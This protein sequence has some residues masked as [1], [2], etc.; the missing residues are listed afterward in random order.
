MSHACHYRDASL[1]EHAVNQDRL[2][3]IDD[4]SGFRNYARRVGEASGFETFITDSASEFKEKVRAWRPTVIMLDL[5]MPGADGIE[6]LRDLAETKSAARILIA[7]GVDAKVLDAAQ[8]IASERGLAMAGTLAKPVRLSTLRQT[9]EA[10]REFETPLLAGAL[11]YA[12]A[13]DELLLE[14]Q[15]K[16]NCRMGEIYGV[17]A[18]I[19]WQHPTRGLVAPDNFIPLAEQSGLI[20][21]M[22]QWVVARATQQAASWRREG[23]PLDMAIN[24]SAR[25]LE[26]M[27]LPDLL[28]ASCSEAG[29][30]TDSVT[31]EITESAAM[32]DPT[33]TMDVLTRLRLKGFNL[34]IDDFGTGYS[35]LVQLR[36]L[37]L[38]EIK[39]D[40]SFVMQMQRSLDSR[41]IV[42][43]VIGLGQKL[44]HNVVAEGVETLEIL[45]ALR[46]LGV[47]A[48]QGY[49]IG[50]PTRA[51]K[52]A[53]LIA[54][55]SGNG[56]AAPAAG[57]N[58]VA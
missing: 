44:G 55:I 51:D 50:R 38:S 37:P 16:F 54:K 17:E 11:A 45:D 22:T 29:I 20:H 36:R 48:A 32:S 43:A 42:E 8:R 39:I 2:L 7:S 9:L 26:Q 30:A 18:L 15:P 23:L 35:S 12:I 10:L 47:D 4:D 24:I 41:V 40:K 27:T 31:L 21:D 13:H 53:P 52:I 57:G 56:W 58:A 19:R 25:N 5:N 34:S 33:E 14:Y 46:A 6:L 3:I 49:F 1:Q 28:A